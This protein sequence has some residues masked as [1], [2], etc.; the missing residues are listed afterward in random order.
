MDDD[1]LRRAN[2]NYRAVR[3]AL[4]VALT[5]VLMLLLVADAVSPEYDLNPVTL[6]ALLSTILTLVGIEVGASIFGRR[7]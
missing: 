6:T 1:P 2:G 3:I 7:K 4:A 5:G